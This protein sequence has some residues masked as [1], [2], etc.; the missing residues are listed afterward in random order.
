MCIF[1]ERAAGYYA[2]LPYALAQQLVELPW[3]ALQTIVY[4]S[5]VY[6][7]AWL[8]PGGPNA[9]RF[10]LFCMFF[11]VTL[12]IF[13]ILGVAAVNLTPNVA[14]ANVFCSFLFGF[15][16]LFSGFLLPYPSIPVW[17]QWVFW[18]NPV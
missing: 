11:Y 2:V 7:A 18:L 16:N 3:L 13:T 9:G 1:R 15:F 6:W 10:F 5:I 12:T 8:V 17:Y 4:C 14:M